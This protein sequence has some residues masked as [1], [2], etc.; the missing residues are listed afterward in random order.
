LH[1]KLYLFGEDEAVVTS[2]NMTA[3]GL[4]RNH[5]FGLHSDDPEVVA[6]AG[7]YF[8]DLWRL[9][10]A[11]LKLVDLERWDAE[12]KARLVTE[13]R[14]QGAAWPDYGA[15]VKAEASGE[16]GPTSPLPVIS[17]RQAFVK[18]LGQAKNRKLLSDDTLSEIGR[19]GAHWALGYP[20]SQRPRAVQDGDVIY[21]SR[22]V[23]VPYDIQVFGRARALAHVEGRDEASEAEKRVREWKRNWP[24]Y[25]RVYDAEFV[26]GKFANGVSLNDLMKA[27]GAR[28]FR[29]T[30]ANS[31]RGQGNTDPWK[32]YS[33]K[34]AVQLSDEGHHWLE[35]ELETK[36]ALHGTLPVAEVDRVEAEARAGLF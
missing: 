25:I 17:E 16:T 28:S 14:S 20:G 7:G 32:A 5:E 22:L 2:A 10:G 3:A 29:S 33:Q 19:S 26:A 1:A 15:D 12:I 30:L 27:L 21:I 4:E 35:R 8:E 18:F 36:F 6:S 23:Q 34:P 13:A 11:D 24:N 9:A 31:L